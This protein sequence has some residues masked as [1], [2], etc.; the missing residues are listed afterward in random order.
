MTQ[1]L[2]ANQASGV[3]L[4]KRQS[5]GVPTDQT[6]SPWSRLGLYCLLAAV[7]TMVFLNYSMRHGRLVAGPT[8]D[9]CVYMVDGLQRIEF[10]HT[11][12]KT[13]LNNLLHYS[14]HSPFSTGAAILAF[15]VF[16][17]HQWAPYAVNGLMV[18][19]LLL[20]VDYLTIG[21]SRAARAA[22]IL[23]GLSFP[24][25]ASLVTEF[26]PDCAVG[27]VTA[28]GLIL[29]LKTSPLAASRNQALFVGLLAA[30]ALLIKPS[31]APFTVLSFG[32]AWL[33]SVLF[34]H[35]KELRSNAERTNWF[36]R[37]G[38]Y[39]LPS[40]V[41]AVPYYLISPDI[42]TY[43]YNQAFGRYK[44]QWA[45][46]DSGVRSVLRFYWDG[47]GGQMMLGR[48]KYVVVVMALAA[49]FLLRERAQRNWRL[50]AG[51]LVI[52]AVSYIVPTMTR[53]GNP[54]FGANADVL[55]LSALF[56]EA[57]VPGNRAR[58]VRGV[59]WAAVGLS[60][61]VFQWPPSGHFEKGSDWARAANRLGQQLYETVRDYP[62]SR[63]ARVFFTAPGPV[64]DMLFRYHAAGDGLKFWCPNRHMTADLSV[65]RGEIE[66]ADFVIASEAESG[67]AYDAMIAPNI[68]GDA[69]QMVQQNPRFTELAHFP[70]LNG[71]S[72]HVFVRRDLAGSSSEKKVPFEDPWSP[73]YARQ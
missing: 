66:A 54:F 21:S 15:A 25:T 7:F 55:V 42:V 22:A 41:L 23:F 40:I 51:Y 53:M 4:P 35:S 52:L 59:A 9:D 60:L 34:V 3:T 28:F 16:G 43:I 65:I 19:L 32:S 26:R 12:P 48:H 45:M 63:N 31:F 67:L 13:L 20:A 69:L 8:D 17:P 10:L 37:I 33:I 64:D 5:S 62:N 73:L 44:A 18:V 68:Q 49:A 2:Y 27:V 11:S 14:P 30:M 46:K 1:N 47:A 57:E 24:F 56:Q 71:K 36:G 70:A 6:S 72:F 38:W 39:C 29:L 61:I 50:I 58:L